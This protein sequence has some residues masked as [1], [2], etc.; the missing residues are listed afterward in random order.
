MVERGEGEGGQEE[1][2]LHTYVRTYVRYVRTYALSLPLS[3]CRFCSS[4]VNPS[5]HMHRILTYVRTYVGGKGEERGSGSLRT[6]VRTYVRIFLRTYVRTYVSACVST[7]VRTQR[8][9]S[10]RLATRAHRPYWNDVRTY[11]IIHNPV[12]DSKKPGGRA[13]WSAQ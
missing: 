11:L 7:H 5:Q 9:V 6:Y 3:L 1:L 13:R 8:Y 12:G 4:S 10:P 2:P